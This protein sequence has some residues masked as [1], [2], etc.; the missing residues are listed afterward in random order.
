MPPGKPPS[1]FEGPEFLCLDFYPGI[2]LSSMF[3]SLFFFFL[4]KVTVN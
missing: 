4:K 2:I 3:L 1:L